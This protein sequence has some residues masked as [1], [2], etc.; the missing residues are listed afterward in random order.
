MYSTTLKALPAKCPEKS[1]K[2]K[3]PL[4]AYLKPQVG[5]VSLRKG[6]HIFLLKTIGTPK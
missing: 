3:S 2:Y 1:L 4:G 5:F 6:E